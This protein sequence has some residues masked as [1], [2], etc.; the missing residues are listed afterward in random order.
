MTEI[1]IKTNNST[2]GKDNKT[3]AVQRVFSK[4][5]KSMR[6]AAPS[7]VAFTEMSRSLGN[8]KS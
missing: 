7:N 8:L 3:R 4:K 1:S 2:G 5:E 6:R